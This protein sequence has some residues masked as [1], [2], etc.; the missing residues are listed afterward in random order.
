MMIMMIMMI[1]LLLVVCKIVLFSCKEDEMMMMLML[2][3]VCRVVLFSCKEAGIR[4]CV[5]EIAVMLVQSSDRFPYIY[6]DNF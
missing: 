6:F 4:E 2:F 3:V 1:L 5:R